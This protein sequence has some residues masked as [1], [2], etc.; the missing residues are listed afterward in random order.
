MGAFKVRNEVI[1]EKKKGFPQNLATSKLQNLS[2]YFVY[3]YFALS[4]EYFFSK[5]SY[6]SLGY[7]LASL[8]VVFTPFREED[9][10]AF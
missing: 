7:Y 1:R 8:L 5:K 10:F 3:I 9:C 4:R 6:N 2:H